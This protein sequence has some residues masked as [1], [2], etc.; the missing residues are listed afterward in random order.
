[1]EYSIN[2]VIIIKHDYNEMFCKEFIK[3][4]KSVGLEIP[5]VKFENEKGKECFS[6]K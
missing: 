5:L 3:F 2:F 6:Y 4:D 1:M